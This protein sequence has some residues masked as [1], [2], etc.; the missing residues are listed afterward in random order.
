MTIR[1]RAHVAD[2]GGDTMS[3]QYDVLDVAAIAR[4]VFGA[5]ATLAVAFSAVDAR[6]DG[7]DGDFRFWTSVF[8]TLSDERTPV[9][10]SL[11]HP[12]IFPSI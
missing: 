9:G 7:R 4:K 6:L 11:H 5:D 3:A 10:S 1:N 12:L 8:R 2:G